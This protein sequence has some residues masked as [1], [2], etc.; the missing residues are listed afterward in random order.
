MITEEIAKR[1]VDVNKP[2]NHPDAHIPLDEWK[3]WRYWDKP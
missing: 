1:D 3:D 2:K